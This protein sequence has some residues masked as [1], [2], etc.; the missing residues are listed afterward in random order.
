VRSLVGLI[1]L[2]A[3]EVLPRAE[4]EP[5]KTFLADMEWFIRNRPDIIGHACYSIGSGNQQR[6]V[7]S[8]VD[9]QQFAR[10]M[11]RLAD[12]SEFLS[13]VGLRSLSKWHEE[14]PYRFGDITLKYEPAESGDGTKGGNSNWRGPVW[15]PTTY[16]LIESLLRFGEALGPEFAVTAP[17]QAAP[18]RPAELAETVAN[19]LISI[20]KRDERGFRP[21][22]GGTMK[23]QQ[24]PHWRDYLLFNEYYHGDNGAGLGASHQTGWTGLVANLIDE[25]RR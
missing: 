21:C 6:Y 4:L 9:P 23:F 25:W 19:R 8:V 24:D 3:I 10:V 1:P 12:S 18:V 5:H 14:H 22:Y 2:Y 17:G 7:L 11:Q 20:F 15:F 13:P 16:L